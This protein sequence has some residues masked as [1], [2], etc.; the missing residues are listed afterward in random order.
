MTKL[1]VIIRKNGK[2][3]TSPEDLSLLATPQNSMRLM[4]ALE[5]NFA[6]EKCLVSFGPF[7]VADKET[8]IKSPHLDVSDPAEI[9]MKTHRWGCIFPRAIY[10]PEE[11]ILLCRGYEPWFPIKK[12][13]IPFWGI[14]ANKNG[15][16]FSNPFTAWRI[17]KNVPSNQGRAVIKVGDIGTIVMEN[18]DTIVKIGN[19]WYY[20]T[21]PRWWFVD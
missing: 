19:E 18:N 20:V 16:A 7:N 11:E 12:E 14:Y 6:I 10:K 1:L 15:D 5:R 21:E 13:K 3:E 9:K 2:V 17:K 4:E 8:V